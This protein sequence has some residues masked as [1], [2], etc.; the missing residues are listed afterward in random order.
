MKKLYYD[1]PGFEDELLS[2]VNRPGYPPEIEAQVGAIIEDI[3]EHGNQAVVKY[4]AQFDK[5]ELDPS[6]FKVTDS[7]INEAA[8]LLSEREKNAIVT[9]LSQIR[10]FASATLPHDWSSSPRS[11]V[12]LGEKFT[13]LDRVGVYI[14]GGTAPL[15]STVLHTAGIA[16]VAKVREIVATTPANRQGKVHPAVL[17]AMRQAGVTEIY[18]LGGVYGVAALALGTESIRP[19]QKLVGPGNAYVTAAKKLLYGKVAIDMV[20]GPSEILVI[21]DKEANPEFIAA[22]LLSQAE[23][24]SGLEQAVLVTTDRAMIEKVQAAFLQQKASLPKL[25]TVERVETNGIFL[26]HAADLKQA[27]EIAS[28]YAPEHL[29]IHTVNPESVATQITAAG[30]I[31]L[32]QWTPESVGDFC[33]G[34][35]HVLPTASSA[36]YFNGIETVSFFR[37]SSLVKYE[38]SALEREV[39]IVECFGEMEDL[40]AHGRAGTIRVK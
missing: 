27:A 24:G 1:S 12:T 26:I 16:G 36:R 20:A 29:E 18:R 4:A 19:V 39:G 5:I 32:G 40:A 37:R 31:F 2:L 13:P 35:S 34:P 28:A 15:V 33:A 30:A 11:G 21:A 8:S 14:P 17:Y 22:D 38:K 23:H 9:A 10:D 7:E 6:C 3:K 25:D